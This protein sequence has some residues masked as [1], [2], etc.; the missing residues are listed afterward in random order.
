MIRKATA[1]LETMDFSV[2]R[3]K[4]RVFTGAARQEVTGLVVNKKLQVA[5]KTRRRLRQEWYYCRQYGVE[6]HLERTGSED[7]PEHYLE[8]LAGSV[9]YVLSVDPENTEFRY[10]KEEITRELA[11]RR[12]AASEN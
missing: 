5:R 4:T 9:Q 6:G 7:S 12:A 11:L 10:M 3:E 2:N 8:R 1:F